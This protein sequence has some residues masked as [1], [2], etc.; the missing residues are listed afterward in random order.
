MFV[1]PYSN[2]ETMQRIASFFLSQVLG[3]V[4]GISYHLSR[5]K[6]LILTGNYT[7]AVSRPLGRSCGDYASSRYDYRSDQNTLD[8]GCLC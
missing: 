8:F 6:H 1:C 7:Q 4:S 3:Q 2:L 5:K